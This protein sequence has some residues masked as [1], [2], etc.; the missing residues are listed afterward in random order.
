MRLKTSEEQQKL[1]II[2]D[3]LR[4]LQKKKNMTKICNQQPNSRVVL[5]LRKNTGEY[6]IKLSNLNKMCIVCMC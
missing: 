1:E 6:T 5:G 3:A 4:D 2:D